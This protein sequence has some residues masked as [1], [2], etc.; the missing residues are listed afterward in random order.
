MSDESQR[1]RDGLDLRG[2][3][4]SQE[5][6]RG[7]PL[8]CMRGGLAIGE[9]RNATEEQRNMAAVRMQK[10]RLYKAQLQ[11]AILLGA[12]MQK[13]SLFMAQLQG[14][15]LCEAQLDGVNL[16]ATTLSDEKYGTALLADIRWGEIN[17]AAVDWTPV[18]MLGDECK[19]RQQ[20]TSD[21]TMKYE[22]T[23]INE[24]QAAVRAN[25]L[26]TLVASRTWISAPAEY[27]LVSGYYLWVCDS[28][29]CVWAS[30]ALS[31]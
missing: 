30:L 14:A 29:L 24:F 2:A 27:S 10:S 3:D 20:K 13:A 6:L 16:I 9:W 31:A 5:N 21:G 11:G 8:V 15:I 18:K 1:K 17:L 28:L 19:A 23:R 22:G 26:V 12:Q 25:R 4:L 7:L